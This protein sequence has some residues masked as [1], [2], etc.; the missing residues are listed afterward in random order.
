[1]SAEIA[2]LIEV[3]D[4]E[5]CPL[6]DYE[7]VRWQLGTCPAVVSWSCYIPA[8]SS[9]RLAAI[10]WRSATSE[11]FWRCSFWGIQNAKD[12]AKVLLRRVIQFVYQQGGSALFAVA[13]RLDR[14]L[15]S[16]LTAQGFLQRRKRLPFY[17]V[18]GRDANL[19]FD[20]FGTLSFLD[21]DMAYRF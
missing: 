18:R 5:W 20:E 2:P 13:S 8:E 19:A 4:Q 16:L 1:V 14:E 6:Y 17:G 12:E 15:M 7:Y 21:A 3:P 9:P 11:D 10:V